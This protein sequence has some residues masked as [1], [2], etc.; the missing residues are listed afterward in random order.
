M[1][2]NLHAK[3]VLLTYPQ[4]NIKKE[5]LIYYLLNLFRQWDPT[6][7]IAC[8]EPHQDGSPHCHAFVVCAK[9]FH[10]RDAA[11]ADIYGFHPNMRSQKGTVSAVRYVKKAGAWALFGTD[12]APEKKNK[13]TE[14]AERIMEGATA[15][16]LARQYPGYTMSNLARMQYFE[17][18]FRLT[19]RARQLLPLKDLP[20]ADLTPGQL[21]LT[22]KRIFE[23]LMKNLFVKDRPLR[24]SQLF[25]FGPPHLGKTTLA[26]ILATALRTYFPC[27]GEKYWDG[28]VD[29]C[30]ELIV[31][32]QFKGGVMPLGQLLMLLDGQVMTLP[33]RYRQITK[34]VNTPIIIISN[35][36]PEYCYVN[37]R[38]LE[39]DAFIDRLEVVEVT[40]FTNIFTHE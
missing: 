3:H 34:T 35:Y 33:A 39:V 4:C 19:Q 24:S 6:S 9:K 26:Q 15:I 16:S 31:I 21:T 7:I 30:T 32:D 14:V 29:G 38:D 11:F 25:L 10:I 22:S 40:Q 5:A 17:T 36:S 12:L 8:E 23:W 13:T 1:P 37:V 28:Y 18:Q 20:W 27:H 2:F